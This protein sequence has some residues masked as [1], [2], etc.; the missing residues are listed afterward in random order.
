MSLSFDPDRSQALPIYR[1][2][3]QRFREAIA[4]GRLQ[5]GERV[6]AVR[7]LAA[8]LN[9]ARGT[10]EAAYQL[11]IG[12]G[13]LSPRGA[14]GTVVSPQLTAQARQA[15]PV[16]DAAPSYQP[17]HS[18]TLPMPLQMGLPALDAFPR[19][20]WNRLAARQLRHSGLEGLVYPSPQGHAPLRTAIATYL[21]I[22]RG[23]HCQ[24]DQVFVCA[25]YRACLDLI[26][27][28]LMQPG[29]A[30]WLEDPGYFMARQVLLEAG[31]Q[32]VPVP[33]DAEGLD[34]AC[35]V[36]LAPQ[37]RFAVVTPTH[38][39]PLGVSLSLPRRLALLGWAGRQ[40]SWI[41]EDDYDSEYRYRGKPLPALKSLDQQER[42]L[43]TGT[44]SK[45]LFPGLRLAYLVVPAPLV[46]AFARQADRLHNHCPL[47]HQA[48]VATFMG[49]GHFA[50]HL[51]R[52]RQLYARRRQ[53]LLDALQAQGGAHLQL[54]EQAGG[55]HLLAL[56][57]NQDD[58]PVAAEAR[59]AGLAVQGLSGWYLGE[60]RRQGLLMGF[61]NVASAEQANDLARRL[62]PLLRRAG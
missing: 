6:P 53:W 17:A 32:L 1:Q 15:Q 27:H 22:S 16:P 13:Y 12:E 18:G 54:D 25:G 46:D 24:P 37:A 57:S 21:G 31:A 11:L 35:G 43:Y 56:L 10:V 44:F 51:N 61:T 55:M 47:L 52:M 28:T 59:R 49:E 42:V 9:L 19:K 2:L 14:A 41:I 50:R 40:G 38:Q 7:A 45:V 62:A 5:P 3:Y 30:C 26:R 34:V 20:L 36:A 60:V 58:G 29:D 39:S 8:E 4:N 33:V 48:T 23:I